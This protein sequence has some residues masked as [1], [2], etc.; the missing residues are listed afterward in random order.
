MDTSNLYIKLIHQIQKRSHLIPLLVPC[1]WLASSL[2]PLKSLCINSRLFIGILLK[3]VQI[4]LIRRASNFLFQIAAPRCFKWVKLDLL[5]T[6]M[7][8]G[9]AL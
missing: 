4:D 3:H 7:I 8:V 5:T 1:Q 9:Y 2:P 6:K